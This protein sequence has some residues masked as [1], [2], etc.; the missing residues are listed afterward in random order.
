[1]STARERDAARRR[2]VAEVA[3]QDVVAED[4]MDRKGF[5][6]EQPVMIDKLDDQPCWYF[7]YNLPDGVLELEVSWDGS[8]WQTLVTTF[9]PP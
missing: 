8:E 3:P 1:M 9:G 2:G 5:P 4:F 7:V 6:N